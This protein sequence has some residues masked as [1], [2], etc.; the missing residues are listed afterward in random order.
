MHDMDDLLH[1][2]LATCPTYTG[3]EAVLYSAAKRLR[4]PEEQV[5][6]AST[7]I[8]CLRPLYIHGRPTIVLEQSL[9][10]TRVDSEIAKPRVTDIDTEIDLDSEDSFTRQIQPSSPDSTRVATPV[11]TPAESK[12][13]VELLSTIQHTENQPHL[14]PPSH[15]GVKG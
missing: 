13:Q 10:E 2:L 11:S 9:E 14:Y 7:L 8:Q 1:D 4:E 3:L 6:I 15:L 5:E 12:P